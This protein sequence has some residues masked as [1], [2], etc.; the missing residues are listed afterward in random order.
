MIQLEFANLVSS[1]QTATLSFGDP[2][3]LPYKYLVKL[4]ITLYSHEIDIHND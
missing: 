1:S 4:S 2:P 3:A